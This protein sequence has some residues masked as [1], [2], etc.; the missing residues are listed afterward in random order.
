MHMDVLKN[1]G[2]PP[3]WMVKIME[4]LLKMDDLGVFPLFSETPI[5]MYLYIRVTIEYYSYP[6]FHVICWDATL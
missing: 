4:N 2:G 1:R 3:K 5:C 6:H